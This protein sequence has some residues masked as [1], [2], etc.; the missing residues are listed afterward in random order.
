MRYSKKE[1]KGLHTPE[2]IIVKSLAEY[3]DLFSNN[4]YEEYL[5]RGEPTN[6]HETTSSA[7]RDGERP[8]IKMKNEYRRE[9]FHRI[10]PDERVNFLAFAQH[11][12]IPTNLIDFTRT[13]LVA[14]FFACQPFR[15]SDDRLEQQRGFVYLLKE[16]LLDVTALLSRNEDNDLLKLFIRNVDNILIDFYRLFAD[17][18]KKYPEKFYY[19][20]KQLADDRQ[21]YFLDMQP[22]VKQKSNFPLYND[23]KYTNVLKY[24]YVELN[25]NLVGELEKGFDSL[26]LPVLE[27]TLMLQSFLKQILD[28]E[29]TVWWLNCIPNFLY[30]PLLSFERGRNQQGVFIYQAYLSF[31]EST[32]NTRILSQ[33]RIWPDLVVVIEN[34]EKIL[35]ELDFIGINEKFIYGD[36]DSV[37][38]YIRKKYDC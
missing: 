3:I 9:I 32:Y 7:L 11:H 20:F 29:E 14:L 1:L 34:K 8:F 4:E 35:R 6:Y 21:Y 10:T 17:F 22:R 23:G 12:G 30:T 25:K 28:F 37:A 5:F 18:N 38:R 19:Y 24:E 33:Q 27:Y 36:H 2:E 31:D 15:S 26:E 16:S 13:P